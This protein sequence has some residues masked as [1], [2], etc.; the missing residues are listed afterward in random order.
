VHFARV[1]RPYWLTREGDLVGWVYCAVLGE[2]A[3]LF[4]VEVTEEFR[5]QGLGKELLG[6]VRIEGHRLG[7]RFILL[8]AGE[9]LRPFYE[10]VGFAECARNSIIWLGA[11]PQVV[12]SS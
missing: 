6:A 7:A 1:F 9:K 10:R 3:R 11:E 12:T 4:E 5:G 8:Q 2:Y